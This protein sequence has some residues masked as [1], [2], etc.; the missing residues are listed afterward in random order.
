M[1][2][3]PGDFYKITY[4]ISLV[5]EP[6]PEP[7]TPSRICFGDNFDKK[8]AFPALKGTENAPKDDD[9]PDVIKVSHEELLDKFKNMTIAPKK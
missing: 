1:A 9:E 5:A 7:P 4:S 6:E 3:A 2:S 8:S